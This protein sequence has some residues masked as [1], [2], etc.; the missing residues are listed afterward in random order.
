MKTTGST[1]TEISGKQLAKMKIHIPTFQEQQKIGKFFKKLDDSIA[2]HE[3]EL[4]LLQEIKKGF[5]QKMFV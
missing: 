5:L 2:T 3:K 1:F 4:E